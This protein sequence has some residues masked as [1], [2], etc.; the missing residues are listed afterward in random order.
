MLLTIRNLVQEG[1]VVSEEIIVIPQ[2]PEEVRED[3]IPE[4]VPLLQKKDAMIAGTKVKAT[5]RKKNKVNFDE[6]APKLFDDPDPE[7]ED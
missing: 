3:V 1:V 5:R 2:S 4:F 6:E 7:P